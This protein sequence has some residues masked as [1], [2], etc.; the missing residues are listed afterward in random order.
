MLLTE[1]VLHNFGVYR[2]RHEV[3]L[4]PPSADRP[5]VLIG[6]LNGA[7]K[8]TFLDALQLALYGHRAR[9]S[10]RAQIGYDE[11]LRRCINRG[12]SQEDGAALEISFTV[13]RDAATVV[14][15][16]LSYSF[17]RSESAALA[18]WTVLR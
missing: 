12:V 10:N 7:G 1:L 14:K 13:D 3:A 9:T 2:G 11:Y 17:S 6:G 16:L 15:S 18:I 4:A 8:T 5:V